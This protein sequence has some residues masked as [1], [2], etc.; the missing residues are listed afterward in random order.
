[1]II[2]R[3]YMF[4]PSMIEKRRRT[5]GVMQEH[6]WAPWVPGWGSPAGR[7][8]GCSPRSAH[9]S[10]P[11]VRSS[12]SAG[13]SA[14]RACRA[15]PA[16]VPSWCPAHLQTPSRPSQVRLHPVSGRCPDAEMI[17]AEFLIS[18]NSRGGDN[19]SCL[20]KAVDGKLPVGCF[21][22]HPMFL[23]QWLQHAPLASARACFKLTLCTKT[24]TPC[25]LESSSSDLCKIQSRRYGW[26]GNVPTA[27]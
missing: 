27:S 12:D 11:A 8:G 23:P 14:S 6:V 18:L 15:A 1:M 16:G 5:I 13:P 19:S 26:T 21:K 22:I 7:G 9:E 17:A 3:K 4:L 20:S 25:C 10:Y 24:N 2:L